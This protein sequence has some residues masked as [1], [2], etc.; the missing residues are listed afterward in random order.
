MKLISMQSRDNKL[1]EVVE[2]NGRFYVTL[3]ELK[4]TEEED[5]STSLTIVKSKQEALKIAEKWLEGAK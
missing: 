5:T 2:R 4:N 3:K 1:I